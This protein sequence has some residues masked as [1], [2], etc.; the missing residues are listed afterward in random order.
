MEIGDLQEFIKRV[1]RTPYNDA[2]QH[3]RTF[4]SERKPAA[5]RLRKVPD[6]SPW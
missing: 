4:L 2:F 6:Q 3:G 1:K 5:W